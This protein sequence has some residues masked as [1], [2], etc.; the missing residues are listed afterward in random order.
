VKDGLSQEA[1]AKYVEIC[2]G[3]L[4]VW[5]WSLMLLLN[6]K[7]ENQHQQLLDASMK[8]YQGYLPSGFQESALTSS[9]EDPRRTSTSIHWQPEPL[10]KELRDEVTPDFMNGALP[11]YDADQRHMPP[12]NNEQKIWV[13]TEVNYAR[14]S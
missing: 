1:D 3:K 7:D 10:G 6:I 5:Y 11:G 4:P 14:C 12:L 13:N 2:Q 9:V 8:T